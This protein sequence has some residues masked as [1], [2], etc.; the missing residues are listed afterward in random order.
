MSQRDSSVVTLQ[1]NAGYCWFHRERGL[2][3]GDVTVFGSIAGDTTAVNTA[4]DVRIS[5]YNHQTGT[6]TARTL[7]RFSPPDD[8]NAPALCYLGEGVVLAMWQSHGGDQ[9]IR[10]QTFDLSGTRLSAEARLDVKA[11]ATYSSVFRLPE[12]STV[13]DFHRGVGWNPNYAVSH[14]GGASFAYGGRLI[15]WPLPRAAD[16]KYTGLDG[17]RPYIIYC[18][19]GHRIHFAVVED[20][21]RAYDNSVYHGYIEDGA[22]FDSHGARLGAL[23]VGEGLPGYGYADLTKVYDGQSD[24]VAWVSDIAAAA[25]GKVTIVFSVQRGGAAVRNRGGAGG[26]DLRYHYARF[27][28]LIWTEFEI[29]CAGTCLYS[30][31]DDYS[32]L[33]TINPEN[34]LLV[35]FSANHCPISNLPLLSHADGQRHYE[36]FLGEV[37]PAARSVR[38]Q[39]L[40]A[41]SNDDNIRPMFTRAVAGGQSALFW[42]AGRY[43]SYTSFSTRV[44]GRALTG[45]ASGHLS[46]TAYRAVSDDLPERPHMPELEFAALKR[47]LDGC[48]VYLEYGCGGSTLFAGQIGVRTIYSVESNGEWMRRIQAAYDRRFAAKGLTLLTLHAEI[49]PTGA[50][51][52]P[53]DPVHASKWPGYAIAPWLLL[54]QRQQS[55]RVVLIDGRF[56]VACFLTTLAAATTGTIILFDD[57]VDRPHYH[58]VE[59]HCPRL[60]T[61]GRMAVFRVA[62]NHDIRRILFDLIP[63]LTIPQ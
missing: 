28:G 8:H 11:G 35:A 24:A 19:A 38:F 25:D 33:V 46:A 22:V 43:R 39:A 52:H 2:T 12:S 9:F 40:T 31:E 49:G 14:D 30:G 63:H 48:D 42:M 54:A 44:V 57:Y 20:H 18:Q 17:G 1:D 29:A 16:S 50:W 23:P 37:D 47:Y 5:F 4:G 10:S 6:T 36:I 56:R 26:G 45:Q 58:V 55:P 53:T 41:D 60:V 51:G 34:Q 62:E 13:L 7:G 15:N 61:H 32:G 59:A 21:P 3:I 27:D